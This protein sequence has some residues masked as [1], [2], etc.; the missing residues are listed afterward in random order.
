VKLAHAHQ[1]TTNM[2]LVSA[3]LEVN[4]AIRAWIPPLSSMFW[5]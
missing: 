5:E 4:V 2:L 1:V 3:G